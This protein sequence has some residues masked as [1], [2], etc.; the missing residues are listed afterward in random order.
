MAI[1]STSSWLTFGSF[2][3]KCRIWNIDDRIFLDDINIECDSVTAINFYLKEGQ[4]YL[5]TGSE[6]GVIISWNL[7][8]G[9]SKQ[10]LGHKLSVTSFIITSD[11][12]RMIS[13]AKDNL[14][15]IWELNLAE[16]LFKIDI[17]EPVISL[18]IMPIKFRIK[19]LLSIDG[20]ECFLTISEQGKFHFYLTKSGKR[21]S[22][23]PE[24]IDIPLFGR[25]EDKSKRFISSAF[26]VSKKQNICLGTNEGALLFYD[27]DDLS[28]IK[29]YYGGHNDIVT[30]KFYGNDQIV[31]NSNNNLL[32]ILNIRT[33]E[34]ITL[35]GHRDN[36]CAIDI[37]K[38]LSLLVSVSKDSKIILWNCDRSEF[39]SIARLN[40]KK[41]ITAVAF[42]KQS[43]SCVI[44]AT[45]C[46]ELQKW[47]IKPKTRSLAKLK[48]L[49]SIQA[50]KLQ[51]NYIEVDPEDS[52][53][54]SVSNDKLA[55]VWDY[56]DLGSVAICSKHTDIVS[57]GKFSPFDKVFVT[58]SFDKTLKLWSSQSYQYLQT[59][60]GH[61]SPILD[62]D[63][64]NYDQLS[65]GSID[66]Q[67]KFWNIVNG[68][69]L[70]SILHHEDKIQAIAVNI[71]ND[72]VFTASEDAKSL[73]K[74]ISREEE[75]I[76]NTEEE[77]SMDE[78]VEQSENTEEEES[79]DE[80]V[81]QS[82]NTEEESNDES[83][84]Q[85][86]YTEEDS[87][88]ELI[89]CEKIA[90]PNINDLL[91]NISNNFSELAK[92]SI[93]NLEDH[94]LEEL[95]L[96]LTN[97]KSEVCTDNTKNVLKYILENIDETR[98][99]SLKRFTSTLL[100]ELSDD[101]CE[102]NPNDQKQN[103][104]LLEHL[105]W[106]IDSYN[107]IFRNQGLSAPSDN[108]TSEDEYDSVTRLKSSSSDDEITVVANPKLKD[109]SD[110]DYLSD[111]KSNQSFSKNFKS[112]LDKKQEDESVSLNYPMLD[113]STEDSE[114]N[115]AISS[116]SE[117][118][119]DEE[120]DTNNSL[121]RMSLLSETI[122]GD[123][124][125]S[126]LFLTK[127]PSPKRG[128][129]RTSSHRKLSS[130]TKRRKIYYE[131]TTDEEDLSPVSTPFSKQK[132]REMDVE[133][134]PSQ[135]SVL[136]EK[137]IWGKK[138]R[139]TQ[140]NSRDGSNSS[141]TPSQT[142]SQTKSRSSELRRSRKIK[143]KE[144]TEKN[145]SSTDISPNKEYH[146][147]NSSQKKL[148]ANPDREKDLKIA[149]KWLSMSNRHYGRRS[150]GPNFGRSRSKSNEKLEGSLFSDDDNVSLQQST[151]KSTNTSEPSIDSDDSFIDSSQPQTLSSNYH[152][153]NGKLACQL[154][155]EKIG[156]DKIMLEKATSNLIC[157]SNPPE[158]LVQNEKI[159][160]CYDYLSDEESDYELV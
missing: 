92:E 21:I 23:L 154:E 19:K 52:V 83:V 47:T 53:L 64:L 62:F 15:I 130:S 94:D 31:T 110:N 66:G 105:H 118:T 71:Q 126:K 36:I 127:T 133:W 101:T 80:S 156:N 27:F 151:K 142:S 68:E 51:I 11:D 17:S 59:F 32:N 72:E 104:L 24:P 131:S 2:D 152:N 138:R 103:N 82:E 107:L 61:N 28:R 42:P 6:L 125:K 89:E 122:A 141:A 39:R 106:I 88:D 57:C 12:K 153:P 120:K 29:Q 55:K 44:V 158:Q 37:H 65:S 73:W 150:I 78:S 97:A 63:F 81:E 40:H 35:T 147:S 148:K 8:E 77:E 46:G 137:K 60:K 43:K 67:I 134:D 121:K 26:F 91:K 74:V 157:M 69:C 146:C 25:I 58:S 112:S 99:L 129:F 14:I 85:T 34:I 20:T 41:S 139:S 3:D 159:S 5:L 108:K 45:S 132:K 116:K 7:K 84:E 113:C 22:E 95:L 70:Q 144:D 155:D 54:L 123:S 87:I 9:G 124:E 75:Q 56:G 16:I 30:A 117:S 136:D 111:T 49:N 140:L 10:F 102:R 1:D 128:A 160:N 115:K 76:E 50:H 79:M 33:A 13:T 98:I 135:G 109:D 143:E 96:I 4:R 93:I 48:F 100:H 90:I 38:S 119:D 86:D 145:L 18:I 114:T 149:T